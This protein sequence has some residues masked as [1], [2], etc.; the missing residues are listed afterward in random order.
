[1]SG[2]IEKFLA[3]PKEVKIG[4]ETVTV[5]PLS[6]GDFDVVMDLSHKDNAV[7]NKAIREVLNKTI[8]SAFPE[9]T[10]EDLDNFSF[11]FLNDVMNAMIEV[12]NLEIS[13]ADRKKL[14]TG[15]NEE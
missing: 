15:L 7:K 6:M 13:D 3:K 10:N 9:A 4:D 12:N 11:E 1:M 8:K 2:R 14:L 5:K